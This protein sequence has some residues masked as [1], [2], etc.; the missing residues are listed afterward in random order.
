MDGGLD[1]AGIGIIIPRNGPGTGPSLPPPL[2]SLGVNDFSHRWVASQLNLTDGTIVTTWNDVKGDRH[3]LPNAYDST[4]SIKF[5]NENGVKYVRL[6]NGGNATNTPILSPAG[7]IAMGNPATFAAIVRVDKSNA[8]SSTRNVFREFSG[9]SLG[10]ASNDAWQ[11][12]VSGGTATFLLG[13]T[14]TMSN[15]AFMLFETTTAPPWTTGGVIIRRDAV[16][17]LSPAG[18]L[19]SSTPAPTPFSINAA[20]VNSTP[21]EVEIVEMARWDRALDST[22]RTTVHNAFKAQ[23]NFLP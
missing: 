3:L 13:G 17:T 19:G 10:R 8:T 14:G 23:Y 1:M 12:S 18:P 16:E 9:P 6:Q 11:F 15:F 21:W 2:H 7:N 22:E 4:H 20:G 5:V